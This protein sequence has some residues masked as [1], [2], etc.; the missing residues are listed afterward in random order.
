MIPSIMRAAVFRGPRD[1][2]V[3][4]VP[5]PAVGIHDVLIR[6][7]QCGICGS[8]LHS[9]KA[10]QYVERGQIMGH[11]FVGRVARVGSNVSGLAEGDRVTG[12][13]A[14]SCGECY[15]CVRD[16]MML[17]PEIFCNSTGYGVGGAFAEYV[18]IYSAVVGAN[19]WR[20]PDS[21]SDDSA[22]TAEPVSVA[23]A[24]VAAADIA[25]GDSVVVLGAG[26]IG[27][28]CMQ[29]AKA[30]G[31]GSVAVIEV[32]PSRLEA[33]RSHGADAVCDARF[34][35]PLEWVKSTFGVGRYH[36]HEGG[37]VDVVLEC[38]G[39]V[40]TIPLS[41]EIVRS[42]GTIVFVSLPSGPEL[43]DFSKIVHKL[44]RVVGSLGGDLGSAVDA[45][46]SGRVR[47]NDLVTHHFSLEDAPA[48]FEAQL[49]SEDAVKVMIRP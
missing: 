41:F 10:G 31:A 48:A 1:I 20:I 42:G 40:S 46:A 14:G 4:N 30:A 3:E 28:V 19:V 5:V 2:I 8:D 45:L 6:V 17:C 16:Q 23:L 25:P 36:F 15:W 37:M 24:A 33:A 47:T 7:T 29:A 12:F 49:G 22:A 38:A 43:V 44:P 18:A 39:S 32:S 34:T 11:E 9:Y 35:N 21:M 26:M 13:Y 27:N